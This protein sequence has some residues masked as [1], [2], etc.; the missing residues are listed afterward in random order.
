[1]DEVDEVGSARRQAEERW[2]API[3]VTTAVQFFESLF[4]AN[5]ARCRK[6]HRLAQSVVILDE[7]QA[8]PRHVLRPCLAAIA[9]LTR[10]YGASVVLMTATQPRVRVEDG[11][12]Y[13]EALSCVREIGPPPDVTSPVKR[14]RTERL[15]KQSDVDLLALI[16]NAPRSLTI[17]NNR[18]HARELF[19]M[20]RARHIDGLVH[21]ST[22]MMP[23]H[24]RLVL[25]RIREKLA[26]G[27][28]CRLISTSVVEAGV[29]V[30]FPVVLRAMAGLDQIVQAAG[31]CN[32]E[33][34][35]GTEGGQLILFDVALGAGRLAPPSLRRLAEETRAVL[36]RP[37]A[38]GRTRPLIRWET[39]R[40]RG[41]SRTS[42]R[43]MRR[44]STR[45]WSK[46]EP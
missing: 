18:R 24:R 10:A 9:E 45:P 19:D 17:L 30:D 13:P 16:E 2:D 38:E 31:R 40:Y 29:D 28:P 4:S 44:G 26:Y 42:M 7:A 15:G 35:L 8:L 20:A 23:A 6:L 37:C 36:D 12:R 5:P 22:A 46:P 1:M 27:A 14:V 34:Q 11:F 25:D 32:R 41:S 3:V 33:G 21:L 39:R 43:R